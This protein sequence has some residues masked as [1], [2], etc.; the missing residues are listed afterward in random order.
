MT[1]M[2]D[3]MLNR[4]AQSVGLNIDW[5]DAFGNHHQVT[6]D[7]Q[8]ALLTELGFPASTLP[9]IRQ[10]LQRVEAMQRHNTPGPLIPHDQNQ[11]LALGEGFAP[12]APFRITLE[13][14]GVIEGE[15]DDQGLIPPISEPGYHQLD[16]GERHFTLAIAPV[17]CPSVDE[18][19]GRQGVRAWGL[20]AQLYSLR[21]PGDGGLGDALALQQLARRAAA[22][23][24]DALAISPVHAIF[25]ADPRNYSPYSPSSR[26]FLNVLHAAPEMVL[27]KP[28]VQRA[29]AEL[30]LNAE[31]ERLEGLAEID[32]PAVSRVRL[33]LLRQLFENFG[34]GQQALGDDLRHFV[35]EGGEAL[36]QHCRFE[37]LH[38]YLLSSGESGDWRQW[39]SRF[40]DPNSSAV[41]R[42]VQDH[43]HSIE[44]HRFTQWL[45]AR[46][47]EQARQAAR[48]SGMR[49]G[50]I[51][52]LAV[53]A[54]GAGSQ[55]WSR[56]S[57]FLP[58]IC[59][60]A[61]PDVLSSTGQDWG[62]CAFSP[63]GLRQ[64]GYRAFIEMIRA[65]LASADGL[66]IDHVM[67]LQRLWIIP[68]GGT[69]DHGAYLDYPFQDLLRLLCLEASRHRALIIGEDLG[70]VPAGMRE[71]LAR[72]H[73]L[74]MRVLLFEQVDG[75]FKPPA[76]WPA[77]ALATTSTHDLPTIRGW[78]RENDIDWRSRA[79]LRP[80]EQSTQDRQ[81]RGR[82]RQAF[83]DA[84]RDNGH[85]SQHGDE[86]QALD[87]AIE[88]IGTTPAPLALLPLEDAMGSIEQP[89]L[90]G[91]GDIHPNWRRRWSSPADEML[92]GEA[93]Q[94]RMERLC[95]ARRYI[96]D[97]KS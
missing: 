23:G 18:L 86:M 10:S 45:T 58:S 17:A 90:P 53:G 56:Q 75:A 3:D 4:L 46:S 41:A 22:E 92:R 79:G 48:D 32:W 47:L 60:G 27:G 15:L 73:I 9:Q 11:P 43:A 8:R 59:V 87:A 6:P 84:M 42:F 61:P 91:P 2:S 63:W 16:A 40:R 82:E 38:N 93:V 37:A 34:D 19:A 35:A 51:G 88:Y 13:S 66:R 77:D 89:N 7:S 21:R 5:V 62:V 97:D 30:D 95:H 1:A 28:A 68:R 76:D 44:F 12:G 29:I 85:L 78:L 67:G 83:Y 54:D 49:I 25:A 69:P 52:D 94:K 71:E 55:V 81:E 96:R 50:I 74:G 70:T 72:S 26:M 33:Q 64:N 14:G 80:A 57:E 20:T 36:D 39:P 31:M 65:N 24:A